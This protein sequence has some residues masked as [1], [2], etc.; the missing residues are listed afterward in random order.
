MTL[1]VTGSKPT[2]KENQSFRHSG[3]QR[4][5]YGIDAFDA[6]SRVLE[7]NSKD[8][9]FDF[10]VTVCDNAKEAY[11]IF[12]GH[13][14]TAHFGSPDPAEYEGNDEKKRWF[15]F[16][17]VATQIARRIDLFLRAS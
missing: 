8:V 17:Q 6:R 13:P 7:R 3:P 9:R 16:L 1:T 2:S 4:D 10:I 15:F 14:V 5:H 12:P 11:P